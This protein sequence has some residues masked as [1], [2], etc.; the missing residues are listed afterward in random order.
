M[1]VIAAREEIVQQRQKGLHKRKQ[2]RGEKKYLQ[3]STPQDMM[4]NSQEMSVTQHE[5][6]G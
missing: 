4:I 5:G 2:V 1:L 6:P 3:V